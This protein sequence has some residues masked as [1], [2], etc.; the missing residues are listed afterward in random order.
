MVVSQNTT[1]LTTN[2]YRMI[3]ATEKIGNAADVVNNP[4]ATFGLVA[5]VNGPGQVIMDTGYFPFNEFIGA[6]HLDIRWFSNLASGN[7]LTVQYWKIDNNGVETMCQSVDVPWYG[8]ISP[9]FGN[10]AFGGWFN[11]NYQYRF[12][13]LSHSSVPATSYVAVD[14]LKLTAEDPW[15][16]DI[17]SLTGDPVSGAPSKPILAQLPITVSPSGNYTYSYTF[18]A[19]G[20]TPNIASIVG[21]SPL[22]D[23]ILA[24]T[25]TTS[26]TFTFTLTHRAGTTWSATNLVINFLVMMMD[27]YIS[28]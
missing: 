5:S 20:W 9:T 8:N 25:V 18:T 2:P 15:S 21:V 17:G 22:Q 24:V 16:V 12:V 4:N 1:G 26:T 6:H 23:I 10:S 3:Q 28:L 13:V 27:C 19:V 14:F 11:Q 7:G